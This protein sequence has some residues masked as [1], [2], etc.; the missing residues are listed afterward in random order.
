MRKV[1]IMAIISLILLLSTSLMG[2]T[3]LNSVVEDTDVEVPEDVLGDS[4]D[5]YTIEL[6]NGRYKA[7]WFE[8]DPTTLS[9]I[10]NFSQ[11]DQAGKIFSKYECSNAINA[12]FYDTDDTPLGLFISDG[13]TLE[14]FRENKIMNGILSINS[15]DIPRISP[16]VPRDPLKI[17]V[18]TGPLLIHNASFITLN[19]STDKHSRRMIAFTT[20]ENRLYFVALYSPTSTFR[21]PL[22]VELHDLLVEFE[23][24]SGIA[25]ADAVNLDGG[26]ASYFNSNG[27][28]LSEIS[29]IGALFCNK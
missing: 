27:F 8:A 19:T 17:A 21:G 14:G 3:L 13:T 26:S 24:V 2:T 10:A 5:E 28:A 23:D 7:S 11:K 20:G 9:L 25:I 15:V 1:T 12:G 6:A 22:M 29:P 4:V 18:Q 16:D